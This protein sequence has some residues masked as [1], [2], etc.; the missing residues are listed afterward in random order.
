ML[1]NWQKKHDDLNFLFSAVHFSQEFIILLQLL[2]RFFMPNTYATRRI[3]KYVYTPED[4][5]LPFNLALK[6][7][8]KYVFG[9]VLLTTLGISS[10]ASAFNAQD[11]EQLKATGSCPRCDLSDANLERTSLKKANLRDANLSKAAL[12]QADLSGADLTGANLESATLNSAILSTTSF[13]GANLKSTSFE[14]A[15]LSYAGFM[16][17]DL[18]GANLK[19][20]RIK[21]TNFRGAHFRLTTMPT[22]IVTSD[23]PYW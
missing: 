13:T 1:P 10:Q 12:S 20:V 2:H 23:K 5:L 16:G 9:I 3:C 11:L 19:G 17:S 4:N 21:F 18:E 14:N 15:D 22:G 8:I 6:N 7:M